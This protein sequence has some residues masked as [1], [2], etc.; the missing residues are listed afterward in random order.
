VEKINLNLL[1]KKI[2]DAQL[3]LAKQLEMI[4]ACQQELVEFVQTI[5]NQDICQMNY[6]SRAET[7]ER[8][9]QLRDSLES[10]HQ[11]SFRYS[12]KINC[13]IN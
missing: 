5:S 6:P 10:A 7:R 12:K 1:F 9:A 13:K 2:A 11:V 8:V 3:N 4:S